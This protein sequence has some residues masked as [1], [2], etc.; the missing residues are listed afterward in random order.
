M[1]PTTTPFHPVTGEVDLA[2]LRAN[3]EKWAPTGVSGLVVGGSTGEAVFLDEQERDRCWGVASDAVPDDMTLVAGTGAESLRTTLRLTAM[4]V[5]RGFNAV[6]VQPP[7][8]YKGAMSD[9]VVRDHYVAVADAAEVPV[10]VY[11]VPTRFSTL[12]FPTGLIA[13][14]SE[15]ENIIGIKDSRGS[16]EKV[17]ELVTQTDHGFQVLV[18]S[19]SLLY[20]SLEIGA[21]GGILGVANLAPAESVDIHKLFVNGDR[22]GAG[23]LQERVGPLHN[24]VVAGM[25]V[26]G[27]KYGLDVL[28]YHGG[29]PRAPLKPLAHGRRSAVIDHLDQAGV[30]TVGATS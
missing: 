16:L 12:D 22:A 17:G 15:H 4:A 19:G 27:V 24:A 11:Q 23:A 10:I 1:I 14:L 18:G 29:A 21:V 26:A 13:E 20:A 28:G 5:A 30:L 3:I 6:L 9:E 25:G 2:G 7:A 8:F